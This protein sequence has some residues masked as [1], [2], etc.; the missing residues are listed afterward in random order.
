MQTK[1]RGRLEIGQGLLINRIVYVSIGWS[2]KGLDKIV[3]IYRAKWCW[4]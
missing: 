4:V 3:Q 2:G 1:G